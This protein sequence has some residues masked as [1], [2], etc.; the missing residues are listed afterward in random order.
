M[1]TI[2]KPPSVDTKP[3]SVDSAPRVS[4]VHG[5]RPLSHEPGWIR[6]LAGACQD[7]GIRPHVLAYAGLVSATVAAF[8]LPIGGNVRSGVG[9]AAL[10]IAALCIP[11]RMVFETV[12][13]RMHGPVPAK[14]PELLG[15]VPELLADALVA[16]AAG[17]AVASMSIGPILGWTAAFLGVMLA[18]VRTLS[19]TRRVLPSWSIFATP[20][21]RM[22]A[23][24]ATCLIAA[25]VPHGWRQIGFLVTLTGISGVCV[26]SIWVRIAPRF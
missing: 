3:P 25:I 13:D 17:Y 24:A 22:A 26:A 20:I 4:S 23:I 6:N 16:I 12:A 2:T 18:H 19:S 5:P 15:G 9:T 11:L 14:R 1:D 8:V 10:V 7:H 21:F